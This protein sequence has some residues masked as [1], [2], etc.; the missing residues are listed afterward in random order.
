MNEMSEEYK[1]ILLQSYKKAI[2]EMKKGNPRAFRIINDALDTLAT[3]SDD[4]EVI[5][6]QEV[7]GTVRPEFI[8]KQER[9]EGG[10]KFVKKIAEILE[11]IASA[12]ESDDFNTLNTLYREFVWAVNQRWKLCR[13][14]EPE[15]T[16][17]KS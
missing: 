12:Y 15:K 2:E 3:I 17:I 16:E 14:L 5:F 6:Q 4:K 8:E 7:I 1:R 13:L 10:K 11:Q 9:Y